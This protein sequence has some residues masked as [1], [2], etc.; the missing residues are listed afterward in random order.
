MA[1]I[2]PILWPYSL[3]PLAVRKPGPLV[4]QILALP[5]VS[6]IMNVLNHI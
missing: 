2:P 1:L 6:K 5:Q 3:D 4:K